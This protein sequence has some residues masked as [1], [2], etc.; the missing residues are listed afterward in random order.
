MKN[1][2]IKVS[3]TGVAVSKDGD[4]YRWLDRYDLKT[5]IEICGEEE[6]W[7][8]FSEL[9][10][11]QYAN[12]VDAPIE[13]VTGKPVPFAQA[14]KWGLN[15]DGSDH[16]YQEADDYNAEKRKLFGELVTRLA[17]GPPVEGLK[18][19]LSF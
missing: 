8:R 7:E 6:Q 16:L 3:A 15:A 11:F 4:N 13:N 10:L 18:S 1:P 12:L 19:L 14:A 17:E 9:D 5:F 2:T